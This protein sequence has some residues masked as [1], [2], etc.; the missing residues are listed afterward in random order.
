MK[1][2]ARKIMKDLANHNLVRGKT[3]NFY[4]NNPRMLVPVEPLRN[5]SSG[6]SSSSSSLA[7]GQGQGGM[8]APPPVFRNFDISSPYQQGMVGGYRAASSAAVQKENRRRA[9]QGL[10]STSQVRTGIYLLLWSHVAA[11][12]PLVKCYA[13]TLA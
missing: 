13:A 3:F 4:V 12:A 7:S 5:S 10:L 9:R 8:I 6:A 11:A 1:R 2:G